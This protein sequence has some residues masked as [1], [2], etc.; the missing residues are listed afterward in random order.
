M[1]NPAVWYSKIRGSAAFVIF[2]CLFV[3]GWLTIHHTTGF[4]PEFGMLNL[5]LSTEASISLAFFTMMGDKQDAANKRAIDELTDTVESVQ[6]MS[7]L[8]LA[9]GEIK[10]TELENKIGS[11][12]TTTSVPNASSRSPKS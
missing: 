7:K 12:G 8:L 1:I 4:D 11:D 6:A 9:M 2:L 3:G 10:K 5:F